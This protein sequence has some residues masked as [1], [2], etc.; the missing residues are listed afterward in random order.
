MNT[1]HVVLVQIL[2]LWSDCI[3]IRYVGITE[4]ET[5]QTYRYRRGN[6]LHIGRFVCPMS[7]PLPVQKRYEGCR[8]SRI[9]HSG[10]GKLN[11]ATQA[12]VRGWWNRDLNRNDFFSLDIYLYD[13]CLFIYSYI[14]LLIHCE[15]REHDA[16]R[17]M[18]HTW[19][20]MGKYIL[21]TD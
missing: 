8:R 12:N 11:F 17:K 7:A 6:G 16:C 19:Y 5:P 13:R 1:I 18:L 14:D 4:S 15:S 2:I 20:F 9:E 3:I 10:V 21:S